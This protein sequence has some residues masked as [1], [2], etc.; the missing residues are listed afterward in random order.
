MKKNKHGNQFP[1]EFPS[2]EKVGENEPVIDDVVTRE[3]FNTRHHSG[4]VID[5]ITEVITTEADKS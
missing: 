5:N 3:V 2:R 4:V 1:M